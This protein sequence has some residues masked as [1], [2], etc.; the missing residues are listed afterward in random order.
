METFKPDPIKVL[1]LNKILDNLPKSRV[2]PRAPEF[3]P[4]YIRHLRK[5]VLG[6]TQDEFWPM[7]FGVN[8]V[9]GAKYESNASGNLSRKL[10]LKTMKQIM[11][12]LGLVWASNQRFGVYDEKSN[13]YKLSDEGR[14]VLEIV[15]QN[16]LELDDLIALV[17][18]HKHYRK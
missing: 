2:V 18:L 1:E 8:K 10:P 13:S 14:K 5:N 16:S 17:E 9:T 7:L 6:L 4:D 12:T 11:E 3:W 15:E